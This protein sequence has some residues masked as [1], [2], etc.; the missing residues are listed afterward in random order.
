MTRAAILLVGGFNRSSE[1]S[2]EVA[3]EGRLGRRL[4]SIAPQRHRKAPPG[5]QRHAGS[6]ASIA[7]QRHR[8]AG[9]SARHGARRT[10]FNR[11]SEAS[12]AARAHPSARRHAGLQSL[13]RGIESVDVARRL[14]LVLELQS[15]LRGIER[16]VGPFRAPRRGL[17]QS[18]LRGIERPSPPGGGRRSRG[19]SIAPQRH[20]K[21]IPDGQPFLYVAGFNRSSEASKGGSPSLGHWKISGLQSLLRGIERRSSASLSTAPPASIAPQRHRK[22]LLRHDVAADVSLQ[23]LLR[24]IESH[25]GGGGAWAGASL[26]SLLRG[27]ERGGAAA[28]PRRRC[29]FNRSSEASK[30]VRVG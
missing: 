3:V 11:S 10:G 1:A 12:K 26:Q 7:P 8:K 13:L 14:A 28:V 23:S 29:R 2:K 17:L 6:V 16:P 30:G 18:L 15:L 4:A 24:G 19:A 21:F 22:H 20:R 9:S 5:A 25:G 27:I